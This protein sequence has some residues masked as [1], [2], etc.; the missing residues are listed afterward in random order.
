MDQALRSTDPRDEVRGRWPW[1]DAELSGLVSRPHA[2]LAVPSERVVYFPERHSSCCN[3][4]HI[5]RLWLQCLLGPDWLRYYL[6]SGVSGPLKHPRVHYHARSADI[7]CRQ[8]RVLF[9]ALHLLGLYLYARACHG[10]SIAVVWIATAAFAANVIISCSAMLRFECCAHPVNPSG[11]LF[12]G[13]TALLALIA[14]FGSRVLWAV[15]EDAD[16]LAGAALRLCATLAVMVLVHLVR[17]TAIGSGQLSRLSCGP[18]TLRAASTALVLGMLAPRLAELVV[19]QSLAV[20][21]CVLGTLSVS[22][23]VSDR[24]PSKRLHGVVPALMTAQVASL[25]VSKL[26]AR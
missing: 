18:R 22:L 7:A 25:M 2:S 8:A 3:V 20:G 4:A 11:S 1:T 24:D 15:G 12:V 6:V 14:R 17:Y 16:R 10:G 21:A 19:W 9:P 23:R 5:G 26:M 13:I